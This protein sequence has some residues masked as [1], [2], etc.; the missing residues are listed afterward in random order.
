VEDFTW[1]LEGEVDQLRIVEPLNIAGKSNAVWLPEGGWRAIWAD[2]LKQFGYQDPNWKGFSWAPISMAL[3]ERRLWVISGVP[4]DRYYLYGRIQLY[5]DKET[6]QGSWNRKF[7]WQ[8]ELL[9][10][11]QVQAYKPHKYTRPD[12]QVDYIQGSNSSFQVAENIKANRATSAGQKTSSRSAL[13][14]RVT[15]PKSYFDTSTMNRVGK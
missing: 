12:G 9:N 3:A 7:S 13:D 5:L 6:Y 8:G 14:S 1:T 11:L 2:D 4:K 10:T 15:Y